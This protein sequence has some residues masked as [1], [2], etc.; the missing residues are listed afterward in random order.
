[1]M[2]NNRFIV[3]SFVIFAFILKKYTTIWVYF[4]MRNTISNNARAL[5]L[6]WNDAGSRAN[7]TAGAFLP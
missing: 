6:I 3:I 5:Q 7:N 2:R 4:N 1:M